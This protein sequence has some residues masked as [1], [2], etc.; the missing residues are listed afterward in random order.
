[1][2]TKR[3]FLRIANI[4]ALALAVHA[5]CLRA[6]DPPAPPAR[7]YKILHIMSY[8]SP[9]RWTDGQLEGFK[10]GMRGL[11]A[12]YKVF[13]MD[14][15]R[16]STPEAKERV[17]R[18]ARALI[19]QWTPDLVYS[20]DDDAQEYV[21]R[22]YVN[23][24]IPFVFSGVNKDPKAYGFAGS[25]NNAGVLEQEHFVELVPGVK[26]IAVVFDDAAMWAPV[27]E[28]MRTA[29]GTMPEI[30]FGPWDTVLGFDEFKNK[31]REYHGKADAIA[32]IGIFNFKD[33][34]GKNV[35][36][37][38]VL[39]WVAENSPLPD[40]GFWIDRVHYGTL[41]AVTVSEH[42]QG[43]EAG[44]MAR[45]IL[46]DGTS[47]AAIPMKPTVKG[48]PVISLARAHKL[49]LRPTTGV[50]LSAEIIQKFEWDKP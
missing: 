41:C 35:P 21:A 44:R 24:D 32:L 36:Y 29:A 6:A 15:K 43:R 50:L 22:H 27:Q 26:R 45:A 9:W 13:Q 1:M 12:E 46:A 16:N 17:G 14:T 37:Q 47:P 28:R 10:E 18:E 23:T 8:H 20:S 38:D 49:G 19:A 5:S 7:P 31:V 11:P 4:A 39:K 30:Q 3:L 34:Q 33:G 2:R 40:L 48:L 25:R 42:E